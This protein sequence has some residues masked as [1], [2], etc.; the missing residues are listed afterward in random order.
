MKSVLGVAIMLA[1]LTG[2]FVHAVVPH[3]DGDDHHTAT[4]VVWGS[5]HAAI[6]HEDKQ[7]AALPAMFFLAILSVLFVELCF[8][9]F[10]LI[11]ARD[12]LRRGIAAYR[13]FG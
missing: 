12:E 6:Q 11:P 5:L 9:S 13:R 7:V 3:D 10:R 8:V 4:G 2:G 1:L